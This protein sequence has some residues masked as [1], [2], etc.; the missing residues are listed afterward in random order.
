MVKVIPK[1]YKKYFWD[2]DFD[3][4]DLM[5]NKNYIIAR[6][7]CY[8]DILEIKWIHNTYSQ[9]EIKEVAKKSRNLNPIVANYLKNKY[10]L[11]KEEM[12]YYKNVANFNYEFRRVDC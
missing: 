4:L 3:N 7:Y 2:T 5:K 10:H 8:G 9:E 1:E 12:A 6:L 11:K